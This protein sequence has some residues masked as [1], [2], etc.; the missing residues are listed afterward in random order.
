MSVPPL[1]HLHCSVR[2][3]TFMLEITLPVKDILKKKKKFST[4]P[5][6]K[7]RCETAWFLILFIRV[8]PSRQE[9]SLDSRLATALSS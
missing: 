1:F 3:P 6:T 4:K 2:T 5:F 9:G 7:I 8:L